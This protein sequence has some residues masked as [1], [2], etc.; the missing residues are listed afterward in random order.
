MRLNLRYFMFFVLL[1]FIST[2]I[3]FEIYASGGGGGGG[4]TTPPPPPCQIQ[5][6]GCY[7]T[8]NVRSSFGELSSS[9]FGYF[10]PDDNCLRDGTCDCRGVL[11]NVVQQTNPD[12]SSGACNCIAGSDYNVNGRCCGDDRPQDCGNINLGVLCSIDSKYQQAT[13]IASEPNIG[14]IRYVGCIGLEY[15]SEGNTWEQCA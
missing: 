15:L 4:G 14:D 8:A 3:T 6:S 2:L 10:L 5:S 1:I 7:T 13:W 12:D 11:D 9:E